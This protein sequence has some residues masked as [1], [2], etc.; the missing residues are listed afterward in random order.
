MRTTIVP[1]LL[2]V[3]AATWNALRG[4]DNPFLRHEFLAALEDSGCVGA[5]T[6]WE[7]RHV[8]LHEHHE[9]L[10]AVPLYLKHHSYGEYVFDW[11][12]ADAYRRHGAEYYPKLVA[13]VPFTPA[14]GA[15]LLSAPGA[16]GDAVGERLVTA[17]R[18]L[19]DAEHCSSIHWLFTDETQTDWL[20]ARGWMRR[21]GYQF[22][23]HNR[24]YRDFDDYL[25]SFTAARR[26]KVRQER[27]YVREA[28]VRMQIVDGADAGGTEWD[29]LYGFYRQ[30]IARHGATPY[31]NRAFFHTLGRAMPESIVLIFAFRGDECVGASLNL[32][33]MNTLY[34]RYWGGAPG[35]NALHFEACYYTPIEYCIAHRLA[36][37][38]AGAQGEHKLARGLAPTRTYSAHWLRHTQ[39]SRAVADFLAREQRGV[40]LY[41]N[42]LNEHTPFKGGGTATTSHPNPPPLTGAGGGRRA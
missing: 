1:T 23:W 16:D 9:L 13:A 42:E 39:F 10:G 6:G 12:W 35:I 8:L 2:D 30:T 36:H 18:E 29:R 33:G 3:P 15:R 31:L 34:G 41:L 37:F 4:A 24:G 25:A 38:E 27:R 19:A 21:T 40:D 17:A 28:G 20:A 32:R 22:H 7:P 26:K 14:T 5:G 11:A